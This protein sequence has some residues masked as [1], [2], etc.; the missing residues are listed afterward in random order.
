MYLRIHVPCL[1]CD[2]ICFKGHLTCAQGKSFCKTIP[3]GA[4][5]SQTGGRT[6][7]KHHIKLTWKFQWNCCLMCYVPALPSFLTLQSLKFSQNLFQPKWSLVRRE[8]RVKVIWAVSLLNLKTLLLWKQQCLK[9][10]R[11]KA[12]NCLKNTVG[13]FGSFWPDNDKKVF[14]CIMKFRYI[15]CQPWQ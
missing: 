3:E 12:V 11:R 14:A 2:F 4:H 15:L 10:E 9:R 6:T 13:S 5:F 8:R 1:A 7:Q